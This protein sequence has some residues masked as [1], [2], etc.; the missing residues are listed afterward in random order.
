[1]D[2]IRLEH[3]T[4]IETTSKVKKSN[5][6]PLPVT[7]QKRM[8]FK[9][10]DLNQLDEKIF[11]FVVISGDDI[12]SLKMSPCFDKDQVQTMEVKEKV[13]LIF[14]TVMNVFDISSLNQLF[15]ISLFKA[16]VETHV[17][18]MCRGRAIDMLYPSFKN[19]ELKIPRFKPEFSQSQPQPQRVKKEKTYKRY[20][21]L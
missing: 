11:D 19:A 13:K 14:D 21:N 8:S 15:E 6:T 2:Q 10:V 16:M 17:S 20:A 18:K 7:N 5:W 1:M 4:Y 12:Q 9:I 3:K